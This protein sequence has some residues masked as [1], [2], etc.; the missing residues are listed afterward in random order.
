MKIKILEEK[1]LQAPLRHVNIIISEGTEHYQLGVGGLPLE[2]DLQ[3]IL[4]AREEELWRV[5]QTIN[6]SLTT[7]EVRATLYNSPTAGGWSDNEFQEA[8]NEN[9]GGRATKLQRIRTL[10]DA[11]RD[12]WPYD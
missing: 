12:E 8:F 4:E 2:G 1:T 6:N 11:I 5:A 7:E 9:F 3:P 10:R